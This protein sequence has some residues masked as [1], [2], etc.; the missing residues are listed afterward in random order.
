M[1]KTIPFLA[2]ALPSL[3]L[4]GVAV[5]LLGRKPEGDPAMKLRPARIKAIREMV[6]LCSAEIHEEIPVKDSINGKWIV[7][8]QTIHGKISFDLDSLRIEERGD[9]TFVSLPPEKIEILEG[10]APGDYEV[11]D[12]WNSRN[13]VFGGQLTAGEENIV[14]TRWQGK[15]VRRIYEKGY[16]RK[17]RE[18]AVATLSALFRD[19]KGPSGKGG[20]VIITDP[21]PGG[22]SPRTSGR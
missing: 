1:K 4:I 2:I 19:M 14:K 22:A 15:A 20:P 11:L 18:N 10:A 13:P 7:A 8:R 17:A 5:F 6:E 21:T 9:T 3:L 16:V 12:S